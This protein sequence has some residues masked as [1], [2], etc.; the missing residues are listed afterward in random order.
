MT[1]SNRASALLVFV[2]SLFFTLCAGRAAAGAPLQAGSVAGDFNADGRMDLLVQPADATH[3]GR[4]VL[5]DGTG[6]M[7]IQIQ[8]ID[9]SF[10]G[11]DWVQSDSTAYTGDFNGDGRADVLLQSKQSGGV[12]A[13]LLTD[14]ISELNQVA[15]KIPAN[16]M[17]VDWSAAAHQLVIGDFNGDGRSDVLLQAVNSND[18]NLI[19]SANA[20]GQLDTT[21]QGWMQGYLGRDWSASDVQIYTGDFNGDGKTDLLLQTRA[22]HS[23]GGQSDY[24][25]ITADANGQFTQV[26][27]TWNAGDLGADW[28]PATHTLSVRDINGDGIADIVLTSSNGQGSNYA[29]L[30]NRSGVFDRPAVTWTGNMSAEQ[31]LRQAEGSGQISIR[32]TGNS[33]AAPA[34]TTTLASPHLSTLATTNTATT[35]NTTVG[36]LNGQSGVNGGAASYSISITV[37]P[38]RAGMQPSLSLNY[39]SKGGNGD[40]GM[41]WSLGGLSVISR[42]PET[43]AQ[44]GRNRGVTYSPSADRLCLDGQRLI[45]VSS[46]AYGQPGS[47]YRTELD[48]NVRV[49]LSGGDINSTSSEFEVDY[50]NGNKAYYGNSSTNGSATFLAGGE[51]APLEWAINE[52]VDPAGNNITYTYSSAVSRGEHH[53]LGIVYSSTSNPSNERQVKFGYSA[54]SDA[55]SSYLAG[56]LT[57]ETK[58]LTSITTYIGVTEIRQYTLAYGQSA[59]TDRSLLQ[60]VQECGWDSSGTEA[61]YVP[62]TFT[63]QDARPAFSQAVLPIPTAISSQ[64][65]SDVLTSLSLAKDYIGTGLH[66]LLYCEGNNC[67]IL[68][69]SLDFSTDTAFEYTSVFGSGSQYPNL[70][71]TQDSQYDQ[72]FNND[73]ASDI[74]GVKN[75][76]LAVAF[77]NHE[78]APNTNFT[79]AGIGI[80]YS[81]CVA[82]ASKAGLANDTVLASGDF[83]GDGWSDIIVEQVDEDESSSSFGSTDLFL[84]RNTDVQAEASASF[85]LAGKESTTGSIVS[86]YH[87]A[88]TT[89]SATGQVEPQSL[90][91]AGDIDGNGYPDFYVYQESGGE[92]LPVG[93]LF[94]A[95]AL[96]GGDATITYKTFA[97]MNLEGFP[98]GGAAP[99]NW[100][101]DINGD[102]LKDILYWDDSTSTWH[103]QL[104]YGGGTFGPDVDTGSNAGST[105]TAPN[106]NS[107]SALSGIFTADVQNDG[108]DELLFPSD[109]VGDY[110]VIAKNNTGGG[111]ATYC[112]YAV[113]NK[114]LLDQTI[115]HYRVIK[116]VLN[117]NDIYVP[118]LAQ[119]DYGI[120]SKVGAQA[121]DVNGDGLTD[122]FYGVQ[123]FTSV[124]TY[125]AGCA[126]MCSNGVHI[127]KET[128]TAP[129]LMTGVTN[130]LGA[131]ADWQYA[132]LA[133]ILGN[134][135]TPFY[136]VSYPC[137]TTA[138]YFCFTSSMYVVTEYRASNSTGGRNTHTYG[139]ENAIYNNKGRGFQGFAEITDNFV[140]AG[141]VEDATTTVRTYT[142]DAFPLSGALKEVAVKATATGNVLS[143][144]VNTWQSASPG[145]DSCMASNSDKVY[146]QQLMTSEVKKY[147]TN[148]ALDLQS[149][150]TTNYTYDS[151]GNVLTV[152]ASTTDSTGTYGTTTN[153]T[154]APDCTN[155]WPDKLTD[156]E[157]TSS[158][159]YVAPVLSAQPGDIPRAVHYTYD[160]AL[161]K[162]NNRQSDPNTAFEVDT[163]YGFDSYG[164]TDSVTVTT[165]STVPAVSAITPRTTTTDY[166]GTDGYLVDSITNAAGQTTTIDPDLATGQ[167]TTVT[168]P[169]VVKTEYTYDALGRKISE[170]VT[171]PIT[172]PA[173]VTSYTAPAGIC[174]GTFAGVAPATA[175][176]S[177][178]TTH[179]GAPGHT[180]CYDAL[181]EPVRAATD[182]FASG[183]SSLQ[184]TRYDELGRVTKTSEPYLSNASIAY[185]NKLDTYDVLN[186]PIQ[187]TDAEGVV[188]AYVYSGLKTTTTTTPTDRAAFSTTATDNSLGKLLTT[189]DPN[190]S[191]TQFRYDAQGNPVLIKDAAGNQTIATYNW[192]GQKTDV[193]DPDMGHSTYVYDVLGNLVRQTDAKAQTITQ[194]YD[195][196]N[197]VTTRT[198]PNRTSTWTYDDTATC[199]N[200]IGQLCRVTQVP[201][202]GSADYSKTYTYDGLGRVIDVA[203]SINS[204]APYHT[205][206][207]YDTDGRV[208]TVDYPNSVTDAPPTVS[209]GADQ[210]IATGSTVTLHGIVTDTDGPEP[211]TYN[212][213]QV[214][215]PAVTLSG[216]NTATPSFT[217]GAAGNTDVF[218]LTVSDGLLTTSDEVSIKIAPGTPGTLAVSSATSSTGAFDVSWGAATGASKYELFQ[219]A[220]VGTVTRS[221]TGT[222]ASLTNIG[223]HTSN[224]TYSYYVE[225]CNNSICGNKSNTAT[226]KVSLPPT[227][228]TSISVPSTSNADGS[229]T[230]SWSGTTGVVTT[231]RVA[232][233][234]KDTSTGTVMYTEGFCTSNSTGDTTVETPTNA[235]AYCTF[236][237][238]TKPSQPG[239]PYFVDV[240]ACNLGACAAPVQASG[241]VAVVITPG[242]PT[243][244]A[245]ALSVT[246]GGSVKLSWTAPARATSYILQESKTGSSYNTSYSG[247]ALSVT[248]TLSTSGD[249][250][251][252]VQACNTTSG[253]TNCG[254]W[255]N[256]KDVYAQ[257]SGGGGCTLCSPVLSTQ[258]STAPSAGSTQVP[259]AATTSVPAAST[260]SLPA[261]V[262]LPAQSDAPTAQSAAS[263]STSDSSSA[264]TGTS[265]SA[266]DSST[267]PPPNDGPLAENEN[268]SGQSTTASPASNNGGYSWSHPYRF[269]PPVYQ[270]YA[271]ATI[272]PAAATATVI[273]FTVQYQYTA[274]G[275]LKA[276]ANAVSGKVYWQAGNGTTNTNALTA[277]GQIAQ[278]TYGN[279]VVSTLSHDDPMSRITE[280]SNSVQN[281]NYAWDSL[282]NLSERTDGSHGLDESFSYDKL[283]RLTGSTLTNGSGAS[284]TTYG[285]DALGNITYKSDTGTYTY[286]GTAG[287][288]AVTSI[289]GSLPGTYQYDADGNMANRNGTVINWNSDNLPTNIVQDA[290]NSSTFSYAPDKHRYQQTALISGVTETTVYMGDYEEVTQ[291]GVTTY[292]HHL[293]AYGREVAEVDLANSGGLVTEKVSYIF[294]DHLGS[295]D[296]VMSPTGNQYMSFGAFGKRRDVGTWTGTVGTVETQAD[297]DADR[298]GF[299]HQ[300]MLDNVA[301][302]HMNGR[303]YDPNLGRFLSVDPVFEFPTNTQSLNPYSYVLNNPLS[304]TDPSGYEACGTVADAQASGQ[305]CTVTVTQRDT[306]TGSHI[307]EKSSQTYTV[308]VDKSGNM[309]VTTGSSA[310]AS[311]AV[312]GAANGANML[313]SLNSAQNKPTG[314]A[315]I[316][317]PGSVS[318]NET[319]A[320]SSAATSNSQGPGSNQIQQSAPG[321][322]RSE[323]GLPN[324]P[325]EREM[326]AKGDIRGYYEARAKQGDTYA[327][328]ALEVIRN[329][330]LLGRLANAWLFRQVALTLP[331][332][333]QKALLDKYGNGTYAGFMR[334][335]STQLARAHFN[336][337]NNDYRNRIGNVPGLLSAEQITAYHEAFFGSLGLPASTFGGSAPFGWHTSY[338]CNTCDTSPPP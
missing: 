20:Q 187:K 10:L 19:V 162:V 64:S 191:V 85:M 75:G 86:L 189:Q 100:S 180:V 261:S 188:T 204:G 25:L 9:A 134:T 312:E 72:D 294:T 22:G 57:M 220:D 289:T 240:T 296:V 293:S 171:S 61:C 209:A 78:S 291:G 185:W 299:T 80:S 15:Q 24:A 69:I 258:P 13:L 281:L 271:D 245:S 228:P 257:S 303:V 21:G 91:S 81:C 214:S 278:E 3:P 211:V 6:A 48:S 256:V 23:P 218:K 287:P 155:W 119:N 41:G 36:T 324:T 316:G 202:G 308:A 120:D 146:W 241:H 288:H 225:G 58:V 266:S 178:T 285:Y 55:S 179:A 226:V 110:C 276:I 232:L 246:V 99:H 326:L 247:T 301:L 84:Y 63:W 122:I 140:P 121:G 335:V 205:S 16:Y 18:I 152:D 259:A 260:A 210:T 264:T 138:D 98:I 227:G 136:N 275:Y 95:P 198:T 181:N 92:L 323:Q 32:T 35:G 39:S 56:G 7:S 17:G 314:P 254:A 67:W 28:S 197:R 212:W 236:P 305:S 322:T 166:T 300:E 284:S 74:L 2:F 139:Y 111:D 76:D 268:Q 282:G 196:L 307:T 147:G 168:A 44:D 113:L 161:R 88:P 251:Y 52:I 334:Y 102:G 143:D 118:T 104:N 331:P 33:T 160:T 14:P 109:V 217:A 298:Y 182:S 273:R 144:V 234:L 174:N 108:R 304:M 244:S 153:N 38:G 286:G 101:L 114:G 106:G 51:S 325:E 173:T 97:Q 40:L 216:A 176:Y 252:R 30:G 65:G 219:V 148:G 31:A 8:V 297:H 238:G 77:S 224:I 117:S 207:T 328:L 158:V 53:I 131:E 83:D 221:Y 190:G 29:F 107:A 130:G 283:N 229:F 125:S 142:N 306:D 4:I 42:C 263:N 239:Y 262:S 183:V 93:V 175:V 112:D 184:D 163:V 279:G 34:T 123:H 267:A 318:K 115:Y 137:G 116:F 194:A 186:R 280:I 47:V 242:T 50:S 302:I 320:V 253:V 336:A 311:N 295:V 159:T 132:S 90:V 128:S 154:Y 327:P 310:Q 317:S 82:P 87:L 135:S 70:S 250:Y 192:L 337:V 213:T 62:T 1:R 103:Y 60:S 313:Q 333:Q 231:A 164:N 195:V 165:G 49:T 27:Q 270:Y 150:T 290:N 172:L 145:T 126:S 215:G 96:G 59:A 233:G 274:T 12:Q 193:I 73:G 151:N 169:D 199:P 230:I 243:L 338:W 269:A 89:D 141:D 26:A 43:M 79:T 68:Q 157:A 321:G 66:Q 292:R 94:L 167:P 309:Y 237:A 222:S 330:G 319:S 223:I 11:L 200:S 156:K 235:P 206:T 129:D 105:G 272:E 127:D 124:G 203:E 265:A 201:S 277:Q 248:K 315:S 149:D 177:I 5:Q 54:R 45:D 71:G 46:V 332:A 208:A 249:H 255:S 37:P 133:Q 329:G 170:Q